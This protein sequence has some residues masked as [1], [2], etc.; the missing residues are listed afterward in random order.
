MPGPVTPLVL[1]AAQLRR[2]DPSAPA[3]SE[4][5]PA[6]QPGPPPVPRRPILL[7]VAGFAADL[8][9]WR[10]L[11]RVTFDAPGGGVTALVGR[12]G[13]GKTATLRAVM[14]LLAPRAG[15]IR[16]GGTD[17]AG[18]P[19][20]RIARLGI[21]YVPE[22]GGLFERLNVGDNLLLGTAS[23][24]I[25]RERLEWLFR[26]FPPLASR[27]NA[28]AGTLDAA[29][30]RMLALARAMAERR[31]LY[32]VDSPGRG[33]GPGGRDAL[34]AV[35]RDLKLQGATI[36]VATRDVALAEALG[37]TCVVL[38][39]GRSVWTGDMAVLAAD[40]DLQARLTGAALDDADG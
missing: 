35:M 34:V 23:G 24:R 38:D 14:G 39:A 12:A 3:P 8:G 2:P 11:E 20:H 40:A 9:P 27:W 5:G 16:I 26:L 13:A 4:P 29:A 28:P 33:L 7:A 32:L 36:L 15:A 6:A 30:R 1:S 31:R 25:P 10:V 37:D 21:G 18:W 19:A 17:V 22:H